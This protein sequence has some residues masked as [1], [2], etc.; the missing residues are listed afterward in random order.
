MPSYVSPRTFQK[1]TAGTA[2]IPP[3]PVKA[4]V[5]A[6][7]SFSDVTFAA[8][9]DPKGL[10]SSYTATKTNLQGTATISGSGL[11]PYTISGEANGE[12]LVITLA[13]KDASNRVLGYATWAGTIALPTGGGSWVDLADLDFTDVTTTS[14]LSTGSS[15]LTFQSSADTVDVYY[16]AEAGF[17]GTITPTNGTGIV[18][19]GGTDSSSQGVLLFDVDAL[20]ASYTAVDV[21]TY[22][23]AIHIVLTNIDLSTVLGTSGVDVGLQQGSTPNSNAGVSRYL[24]TISNTNGTDEDLRVRS[25]TT[26]SAVIVTQPLEASKVVTLIMT[27]GEIVDVMDTSGTTPPTPDPGGTNTYNCGIPSVALSLNATPI[28]Q[29]NGLYAFASSSNRGVLTCTRLLVQRF[30]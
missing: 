29:A 5:S 23:Y 16:N 27:A 11:G 6:G 10:I 26:G 14:A 12:S 17:N 25:R 4:V 3:D 15:T 18:W 2:V 22:Q 19:T 21:C 24:R 20:L 1:A 8:F 30:E 7:G 28:F 13:A 9:I